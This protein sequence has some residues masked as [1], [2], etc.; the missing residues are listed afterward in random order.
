[1][2]EGCIPH[3]VT[4]VRFATF[5]TCRANKENYVVCV[6]HL[7][8]QPCRHLH[9][10]HIYCIALSPSTRGRI[11]YV[12]CVACLFSFVY[13]IYNLFILQATAEAW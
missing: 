11:L 8:P 9:S 12:V 13:L 10:S 7:N 2:D 3:S 1:M 5:G 4:C 6:A